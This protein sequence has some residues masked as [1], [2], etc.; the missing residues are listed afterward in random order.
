M[1]LL[2]SLLGLLTACT[3]PEYLEE[4][5]LQAYI[6]DTSNGV[7]KIRQT[8]QVTMQVTYR[9]IDFLVQQEMGERTDPMEVKQLVDRY[10]DYIYFVLQL[11]VGERD[12][13]YGASANQA[14]FSERLQ[15]LAYRMNRFINLTTISNDTIPVADFFYSRTFGISHS[16]DVLLVF[17]KQE[18]VDKDFYFN[19]REFGFNTGNQSFPFKAKNILSTPKLNTLK[20]YYETL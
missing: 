2:V 11:S 3:L 12:A 20:T 19:V 15:T 7:S 6:Q 9:P 18:L 5:A 10:R 16:T 8:G 13:L 14:V 1:P 17:N 4:E